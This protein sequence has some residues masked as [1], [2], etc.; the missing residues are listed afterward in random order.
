LRNHWSYLDCEPAAR[1]SV[2]ATVPA[3]YPVAEAV[4]LPWTPASADAVPAATVTFCGTLQFAVVKVSEVADEMDRSGFPLV[5]RET[6]TLDDGCDDRATPTVVLLPCETATWFG[7]TTTVGDS[8]V[9]A[10]G[11]EVRLSVPLLAT[12]VM[13]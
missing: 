11:Y 4:R 10:T 3:L 9:I 6:V 7:F 13:E 2:T 8:T 5:A 1:A 12:A